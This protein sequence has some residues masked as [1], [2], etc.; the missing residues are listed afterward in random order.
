VLV[1]QSTE[2]WIS[3]ALSVTVFAGLGLNSTLGW[4]W[5]DPAVALVVAAITLWNGREAW[6][7]AGEREPSTPPRTSR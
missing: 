1:A 7:E 3:N 6:R 2:T 5:A 4:W